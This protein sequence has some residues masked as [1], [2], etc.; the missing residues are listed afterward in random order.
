M[1]QGLRRKRR[2]GP[3]ELILAADEQQQGDGVVEAGGVEVDEEIAPPPWYVARPESRRD[4]PVCGLE[5]LSY[6]CRS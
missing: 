6:T 2:Q 3:A 1:F 5:Q 4:C